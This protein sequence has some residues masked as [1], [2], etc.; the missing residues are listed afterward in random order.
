MISH[1]NA[2]KVY[3]DLGQAHLN[4][5]VLACHAVPALKAELSL[6][7]AAPKTPPDHFKGGNNTTA[8]LL[9]YAADYHEELARSALITLFSYFEA[10]V[11]DALTEIVDFHGG[12]TKLRESALNRTRKYFGAVPATIDESRKKLQDRPDPKKREK[13][14]KHARTLDRAGY[15]FPTDLLA[16][17]GAAQLILKI[18]KPGFKAHEIPDMIENLLLFPLSAADRKTLETIRTARNGIAHGK[19]TKPTLKKVM[20]H[21]SELHRIAAAVDGHIAK[22]FLV[23]QAL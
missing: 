13:Y 3:R 1:T 23:I 5:V 17:F 10:Y 4:F 16:H 12:P 15:R 20:R 8:E 7:G 19:G 9:S 11:K 6:P 22:H 21:S 14:E 2:F 18:G